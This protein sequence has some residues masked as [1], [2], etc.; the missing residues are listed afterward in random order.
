[1]NLNIKSFSL[2]AGIIL[3]LGL[4]IA[5][6]AAIILKL[7]V[8]VLQIYAKLIPGYSVSPLG[9]VVGLIVGFVKGAIA[10]AIFAWLYNLLNGSPS[11]K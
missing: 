5:T 7:D 9:S 3:G 2:T 10:A 11:K 8:Y 6:W 4:F 1:M